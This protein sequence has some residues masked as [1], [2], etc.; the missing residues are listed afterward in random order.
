MEKM[1]TVICHAVK[2]PGY[3][4]DNMHK[5]SA[6]GSKGQKTECSAG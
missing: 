2:S 5:Q 4:Y 1:M 6:R 3:F